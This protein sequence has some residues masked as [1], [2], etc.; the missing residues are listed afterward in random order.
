MVGGKGMVVEVGVRVGVGV[1]ADRCFQREVA[2]REG[3]LT[4]TGMDKLMTKKKKKKK[5]RKTKMKK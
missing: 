1:G 3:G 2:A 4:V 5:M